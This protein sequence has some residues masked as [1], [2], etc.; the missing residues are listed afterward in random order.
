[1]CG[2]VRAEPGNS[3]AGAKESRLAGEGGGAGLWS[4]GP[5]VR[6]RSPC[7]CA[8]SLPAGKGGWS[9]STTSIAKLGKGRGVE[10]DDL[11]PKLSSQAFGTGRACVS[12][13][14][15]CVSVFVCV[16]VVQDR[17][18]RAP[19]PQLSTQAA[20]LL[21]ASVFW[22]KG[23]VP[24]FKGWR[25]TPRL[26]RSG[27]WCPGKRRGPWGEESFLCQIPKCHLGPR[28]QH[29]HLPAWAEASL[30]GL[31]SRGQRPRTLLGFPAG[32]LG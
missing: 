16:S 12:V 25:E 24:G 21:R 22:G 1:M 6:T 29:N 28:V 3:P 7:P 10:E 23:G 4:E 18:L 2:D 11:D 26:H 15:V 13:P 20:S 31:G 30:N 14:C 8:L 19:V 27:I 5:A 32:V 9:V 17:V